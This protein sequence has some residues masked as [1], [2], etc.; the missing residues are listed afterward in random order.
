MKAKNAAAVVTSLLMG[1]AGTATIREVVLYEVHGVLVTEVKR[2]AVFFGGIESW[3]EI[4]VQNEGATQELYMVNL[5]TG[6]NVP[7]VGQ[8]CN[9][10]LQNGTVQDAVGD[11]L[12][13]DL[14]PAKTIKSF[15][16]S[17]ENR[18]N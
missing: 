18:D 3:I 17:S 6:Q 16:C 10:I 8:V 12:V 9:F 13:S 11:Q 7:E 1:C 5:S 4:T 14:R 2:P 15:H